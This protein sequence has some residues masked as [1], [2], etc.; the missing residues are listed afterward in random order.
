MKVFELGII[1]K[2][3]FLVYNYSGIWIQSYF[4]KISLKRFSISTYTLKKA[5]YMRI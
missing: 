4:Q 3:N 5:M 2:N 1:F